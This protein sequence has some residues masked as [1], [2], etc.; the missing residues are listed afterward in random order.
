MH[1]P[2]PKETFKTHLYSRLPIEIHGSDDPGK[3]KTEPPKFNPA[4]TH[5]Q[6]TC[7]CGPATSHNTSS[8]LNFLCACQSK[9]ID[10]GPGRHHP[11]HFQKC[12]SRYAFQPKCLVLKLGYPPEDTLENQF[13]KRLPIKMLGSA[14][15]PHLARHLEP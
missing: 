4:P 13:S 1:P 9:S 3:P 7:F 11:Q 5:N 6:N 10:L 8:N 12:N 15:W 2:T 14:T